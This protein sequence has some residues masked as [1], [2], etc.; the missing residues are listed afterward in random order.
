MSQMSEKFPSRRC[1]QIQTDQ[2]LIDIDWKVFLVDKSRRIENAIN[3]PC[4]RSVFVL[5]SNISEMIKDIAFLILNDPL[6]SGHYKKLTPSGAQAI[7]KWRIETGKSD[8]TVHVCVYACVL[9]LL[10]KFTKKQDR[11]E[12]RKLKGILGR[13]K[14][15]S[16]DE[17]TRNVELQD[18]RLKKSCNIEQYSN[19][20]FQFVEFE[21]LGQ[22][23]LLS[24]FPPT[25]S[26]G[27]CRNSPVSKFPVLT[28]LTTADYFVKEVC[29]KMKM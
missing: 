29:N 9:W 17:A 16:P 4:L 11:K 10:Q 19:L 2:K 27:I 13:V 5:S 7:W 14:S 22:L 1:D 12:A 28:D 8:N 24:R 26:S 15:Q 25:L 23:G 18:L 6:R 21:F 20:E 3:R